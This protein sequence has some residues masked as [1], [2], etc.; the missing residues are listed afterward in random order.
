MKFER[1][2]EEDACEIRK[3]AKICRRIKEKKFPDIYH[4]KY[5][6]KFLFEFVI[7]FVP[8]WNRQLMPPQTILRKQKTKF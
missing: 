3:I 2:N 8:S 1:K 5:Q 6:G 4:N 7:F